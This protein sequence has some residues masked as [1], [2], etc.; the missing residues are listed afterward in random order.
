MK[1][2]RFV[3]K[4]FTSN[5]Y[6]LSN[7]SHEAVIVDVGDVKPIEEYLSVHQLNIAGIFLTHT[8]YDHIYGI[9]ALVEDYPGYKVYTSSFGKEA[10]ASDR[11]NFSR[12]HNDSIQ[13]EY[14]CL[15]ILHEGDRIKIFSDLW[16]DVIETPGHDESC[17]S[18]RMGEYFFSGDSFIPGV[19]VIASFPHSHKGDAEKSILKILSWADGSYL[20]PGHG[21]VYEYFR[22]SDYL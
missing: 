3:N 22:S 14:D 6:V 17:L 19:K 9:K 12:Y 16:V 11:L 2:H 7:D 21:D 1:L 5:S 18:Y 20:C 15:Q 13:W 10:L 4:V 8:H